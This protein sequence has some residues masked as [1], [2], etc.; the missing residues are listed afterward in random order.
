M[1]VEALTLLQCREAAEGVAAGHF[2]QET[3]DSNT[4]AVK[5]VRKRLEQRVELVDDTLYHRA[6]NM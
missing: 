3:E 1:D 2:D 4:D 6:S 5:H